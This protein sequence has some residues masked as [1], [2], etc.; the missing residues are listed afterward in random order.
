M[1][2]KQTSQQNMSESQTSFMEI[3]LSRSILR[4]KIHKSIWTF[5]FLVL[6]K[7][8]EPQKTEIF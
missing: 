4:L 7:V 2:K 3:I 6:L 8:C 1:V 5:D